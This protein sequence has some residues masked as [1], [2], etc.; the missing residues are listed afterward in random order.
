MLEKTLLYFSRQYWVSLPNWSGVVLLD[1]IFCAL[2]TS[3]KVFYSIRWSVIRRVKQSHSSSWDIP[4]SHSAWTEI[5][6]YYI[7]E[8]STI[9]ILWP[10]FYQDDYMWGCKGV[11]KISNSK[12]LKDYQILR[13]L[14]KIT[15]YKKKLVFFVC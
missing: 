7:V 8:N 11:K 5:Q 13:R 3:R 1:R 10:V 9:T 2:A 6:H 4:I 15:K 14:P 12:N